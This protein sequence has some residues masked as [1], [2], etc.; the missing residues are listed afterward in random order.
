LVWV[1]NTILLRI[2]LIRTEY[3]RVNN[4]G[5]RVA[6]GET[7]IDFWSVALAYKF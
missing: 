3:E 2:F 4:V 5:A 1:Q 6:T 7:Q